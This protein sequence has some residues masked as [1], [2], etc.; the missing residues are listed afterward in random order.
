MYRLFAWSI[1]ICEKFGQDPEERQAYRERLTE[2][3]LCTFVRVILVY[4]PL[5]LFAQATTVGALIWAT[6]VLP[7]RLFGLGGYLLTLAAIALSIITLVG[8]CFLI[9]K[10]TNAVKSLAASEPV[11]LAVQYISARKRKFCPLIRFV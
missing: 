9:S 6:L 5:V 10:S 3:N 4:V 1:G 7:I 8:L 11:S 2:T